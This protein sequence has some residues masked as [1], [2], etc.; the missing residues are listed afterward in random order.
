MDVVT[1]RDFDVVIDLI[2]RSNKGKKAW[3]FVLF[4]F[5]LKGGTD[6]HE[7]G[8]CRFATAAIL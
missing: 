2:N 4:W 8:L 1:N 5:L 7:N 3:F 6:T